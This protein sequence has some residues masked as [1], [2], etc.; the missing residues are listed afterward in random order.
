M[1]VA[2]ACPTHG[3]IVLAFPAEAAPR[4]EVPEDPSK[5]GGVVIQG[6][7]A[8]P[9]LAQCPFCA[10]AAAKKNAGHLER[11]KEMM[12]GVADKWRV[13]THELRKAGR[14]FF[15]HHDHHVFCECQALADLLEANE[16]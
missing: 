3:T 8:L 10:E 16:Q 5:P 14:E 7:A 13:R 15:K 6:W 11:E 4:V 9:K 2:F 1:P 12:R